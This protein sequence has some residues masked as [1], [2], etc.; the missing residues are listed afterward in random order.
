MRMKAKTK[1]SI[2]LICGALV[3]VLLTGL[4]MNLY[5]VFDERKNNPDNLISIDNLEKTY[6]AVKTHNNGYGVKYT[7]EKDGVVKAKGT[8][9][10]DDTFTVASGLKLEAGK[11]YTLSAGVDGVSYNSYVLRLHDMNATRGSA[12]EYI[13][14]D[15]DESF[16]VANSTHLYNVEIIVK[17]DVKVNATFYPVLVEGKTAG[18]F[19]TK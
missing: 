14:A 3:L 15:L 2:M 6:A 17:K 11:T 18:N 8:A 9:S 7:V 4:V 19:Y 16:T 13:Y 10:G 1:S 5:G 12:E